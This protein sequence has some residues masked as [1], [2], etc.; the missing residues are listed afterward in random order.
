MDILAPTLG[1]L[2]HPGCVRGEPRGVVSQDI[3]DEL[4]HI[5]DKV[6]Q[7]E[8]LWPRFK[9]K[10]VNQFERKSKKSSRCKCNDHFEKI[11]WKSYVES[12]ALCKTKGSYNPPELRHG[13]PTPLLEVIDPTHHEESV[14]T[15]QMTATLNANGDVCAVQ[16]AGA[17]GIFQ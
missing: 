15:G 14:M 7:V 5:L 6:N 11:Y 3:L 4:L 9:R 13:D 8:S 16:K 17:E 12:S 10:F 2:D 1:K